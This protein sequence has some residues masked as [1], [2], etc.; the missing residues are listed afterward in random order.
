M[1]RLQ[2]QELFYHQEQK[3]HAG[4]IAASEILQVVSHTHRTQANKIIFCCMPSLH[5]QFVAGMVH[6]AM[7]C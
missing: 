2:A 6:L 3:K 7:C 5:C 1:R 4:Q